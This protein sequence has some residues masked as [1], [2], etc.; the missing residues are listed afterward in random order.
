MGVIVYDRF[1]VAVPSAKPIAIFA[2]GTMVYS[3]VTGIALL[4]IGKVRKLKNVADIF[5]DINSI[6]RDR[7]FSAFY[8]DN[9]ISD[10]EE[11]IGIEK[12]TLISVCQRI[13]DIYTELIGKKCVVTV[14]LLTQEPSEDKKDGS[15]VT[16][17][18]TYARSEAD[19]KRDKEKPKR[20][21]VHEGENTAFD[22]ALM[23]NKP[24]KIAHFYSA[25]LLKDKRFRDYSNQ[26]SNWEKHYKSTIVVPI[27]CMGVEGKSQRS[28]IGFLC[29]DTKSRNRL[30]NS[31]HLVMLA[32]LSDQMYNFMSLMRGKYVVLPRD[33]SK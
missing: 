15:L 10:I 16:Y 25:D 23:P 3:L 24:G 27:R 31:H 1:F 4:N 14:K 12:A 5:G 9:Y 21:L 8:G 29:V 20:F 22:Q 13:A 6:Y 2:L 19:S 30:D 33:K 17:V 18:T 32:A 28:D 26:R 7:L 11:R